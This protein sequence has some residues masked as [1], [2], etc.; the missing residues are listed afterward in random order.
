MENGINQISP[1]VQLMIKRKP[2]ETLQ[3][4]MTHAIGGCSKFIVDSWIRKRR[5]KVLL[6]VIP[7]ITIRLA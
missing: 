7:D 3:L 5:L 1:T 4:R 2:D 6:L